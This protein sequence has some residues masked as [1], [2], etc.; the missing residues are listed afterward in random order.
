MKWLLLEM[1]KM[2]DWRRDGVLVAGDWQEERMAVMQREV[3]SWR[4]W[5]R[6]RGEGIRISIG[7][8]KENERRD[9]Q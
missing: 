8:E 1:M 4:G 6:L 7:L 9:V 2:K 5:W 3:E